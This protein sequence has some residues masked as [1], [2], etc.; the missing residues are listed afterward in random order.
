[1][2]LVQIPDPENVVGPVHDFHRHVERVSVK[3]MASYRIASACILPSWKTLE[4]PSFSRP[5][6]NDFTNP[7]RYSEH[8]KQLGTDFNGWRGKLYTFLPV[9]FTRGAEAL[10]E[11]IRLHHPAGIKLHPL[12]RFP[13]DK[14]ILDPYFKVIADNGL[15]VHVHTDWPSSTE[16]GKFKPVLGKTFGRLA[17]WYLGTTFIMGH[18][19]NN[20]SYL[21]IWK[22]VKRCPNCV[23]ETSM[24]PTPS[25]LDRVIARLGAGRIVFGSNF[26]Y[27]N[28]GVEIMRIAM[29]RRASAEQKR[30]ILSGNAAALLSN[31]PSMVIGE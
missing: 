31:R 26:P 29:L 12:Q 15:L 28:T 10:E 14:A 22:V 7:S 6:F 17:S 30:Q 20:D 19:G 8:L 16:Y 21:N 18:A 24:A 5:G 25:E 2:T 27:C 11:A 23:V 3:D 4:A 9:D 13:L 1:M